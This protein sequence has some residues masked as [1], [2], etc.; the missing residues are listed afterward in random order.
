[1]ID[2]IDAL[3]SR[4]NARYAPRWGWH[5][6][7]RSHDGTP[8]YLPALQQVRQEYADLLAALPARRTSA[9]QLGLGETRAAHNA[10]ALVFD[11]VTTIDH[12][13]CLQDV[14]VYPG[15]NTQDSEAFDLATALAP[16]DL[17]L[18]DADHT[19]AGVARDHVRYS[20]LVALGGLIAFH[21]AL[22]RPAYPEV[23]VH[24][25]LA[26]LSPPPVL[27]GTEVGFALVT[28]RW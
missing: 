15:R 10:L 2:K 7:H 6:D 5:D 27:L 8:A 4:E 9:L 13:E 17:L 3:I 11:H 19:L 18:I 22:P 1:M 28:H 23:E 14:A 16:Y 26:T 24:R 12:R 20:P 21:D 25:Y